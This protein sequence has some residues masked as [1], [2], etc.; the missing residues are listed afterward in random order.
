MIYVSRSSLDEAAAAF[1]AMANSSRD[2]SGIRLEPAKL[3]YGMV[4]RHLLAALGVLISG[5][6]AVQVSADDVCHVSPFGYVSPFGHRECVT[7]GANGVSQ[8][9]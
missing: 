3:D 4:E 8:G 5:A 6:A 9:G 2:L 1:V 7:I